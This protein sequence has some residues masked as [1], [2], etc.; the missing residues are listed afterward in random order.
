MRL[1]MAALHVFVFVTTAA[2]TQAACAGENVASLKQSQLDFR[3]TVSR[4]EATRIFF[5][6]QSVGQNVIEG[7]A[8]LFREHDYTGVRVVEVDGA[9][10]FEPGTLAHAKIGV[11]G[12]P[13]SKIS[14][15]ERYLDSGIGAR[16]DVAFFKMCYLDIEESTDVKRVL[17]D[18]TAAVDRIK[19]RYP[20]LRIIHVT[21]PLQIVQTG[22]K[23]WIKQALSRS[24]GG[25]A[26]NARRNDYNALLRTHYAGKEPLLDLAT[27]EATSAD[28]R[29]NTYDY[30]GNRLL[31]LAPQNAA[32]PGH[33]NGRGRRS[34]AE[35]LLALLAH[36]VSSGP[37][38]NN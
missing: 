9:L 12:D 31:A 6:H 32:D 1:R 33:L 15:F 7:V 10:T 27:V 25:Y 37:S 13:S 30:R 17:R 34:A 5:G 26:A 21:V 2:I 14:D 38:A 3:Q 16:A 20:D 24:P 11:N 35:Q 36:T 18:Y 23:A 4:L 29:L 19:A 8:E 22:P 28:G